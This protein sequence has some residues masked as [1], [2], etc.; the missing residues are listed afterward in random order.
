MRA[1]ARVFA[2]PRGPRRYALAAALAWFVAHRVL[3]HPQPFFAPIAAAVAMSTN[4]FRR[5]RRALQMIVGVLLGIGVAEVL[6]ALLGTSTIALGVTVLV[7]MLVA[8]PRLWSAERAVLDSLADAL[9]QA[10]A[11]SNG[12]SRRP[13]SGRSGSAMTF[14]T[15]SAAS[16]R[17]KPGPRRTSGS[18]PGDGT[19]ALS[20]MPRTVGSP[21]SQTQL[22]SAQAGVP[23]LRLECGEQLLQQDV[24]PVFLVAVQRRQQL[25]LASRTGVDVRRFDVAAHRNEPGARRCQDQRASKQGRGSWHQRRPS[26]RARPLPARGD[27][28]PARP[29]AP[30]RPLA[31]RQVSAG[32]RARV[33][34]RVCY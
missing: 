16:R 24:Q 34:P 33:M 12:V 2:L 32:M 11:R 27:P 18:R 15:S 10:L 20:S 1:H 21:D 6:S 7:T 3:G 25:A 26:R 4:Y 14:T 9:D 19:C 23:E 31:G 13:R 5:S 22:A 28:V 29:E 30:P 17:R 8:L